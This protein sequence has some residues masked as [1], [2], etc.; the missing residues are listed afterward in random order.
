MLLYIESYIYIESLIPKHISIY[1]PILEKKCNIIYI[2]LQVVGIV[3]MSQISSGK[4]DL[5]MSHN[6]EMAILA[7]ASPPTNL[8]V[9]VAQRDRKQAVSPALLPPTATT[10]LYI[11]MIPMKWC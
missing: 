10:L 2:G 5:G 1:F 7:S 8:P 4:L 11:A 3:L 9:T 6:D